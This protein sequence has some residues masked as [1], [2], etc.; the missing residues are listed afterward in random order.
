M[1][2]PKLSPATHANYATIVSR[3][4]GAVLLIALVVLVA[5]TLSGADPLGQH[6]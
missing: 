4:R 1:M 3:Q 5:M 6:R 2:K